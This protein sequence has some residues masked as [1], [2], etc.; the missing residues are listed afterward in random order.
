VKKTSLTAATCF[1]QVKREAASQ[2]ALVSHQL[3]YLEAR[4]RR[5][6]T[7]YGT[8]S[9]NKSFPYFICTELFLHLWEYYVSCKCEVL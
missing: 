1:I 5:E 3:L 4:L 8:V 7:R 6:Q 9:R 2:L